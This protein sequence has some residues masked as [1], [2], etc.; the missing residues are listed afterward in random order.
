MELKSAVTRLQSQP[1]K[2]SYSS[3]RSVA[4][5]IVRDSN[6]IVR[7]KV[8]AYMRQLFPSLDA[9]LLLFMQVGNDGD[10]ATS[11]GVLRG[12]LNGDGSAG[13]VYE[14]LTP[15]SSLSFVC[16]HSFP[17]PKHKINNGTFLFPFIISTVFF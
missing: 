12:F 2:S 4:S 5:L 16:N 14:T 3:E 11:L 13:D 6:G 8:T 10:V 15:S 7:A 9:Y 1:R 17:I